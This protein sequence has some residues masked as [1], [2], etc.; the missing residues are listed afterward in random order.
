LNPRLTFIADVMLPS[1]PAQPSAVT[2]FI[3]TPKETACQWC[4][5]CVP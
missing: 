5:R 1:R 2:I 4:S 3:A